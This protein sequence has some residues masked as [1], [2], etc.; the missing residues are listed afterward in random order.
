[1]AHATPAMRLVELM[2]FDSG[3]SAHTA[4]FRLRDLLETVPCP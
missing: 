2:V 4:L 3:D 1:M